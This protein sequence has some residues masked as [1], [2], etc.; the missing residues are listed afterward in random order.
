MIHTDGRP[1]ISSYGS[2][3]AP[4]RS[5]AVALLDD[6][7]ALDVRPLMERE[8]AGLRVEL[9]LVAG[10]LIIRVTEGLGTPDERELVGNVPNSEAHE[11][12]AHPYLYVSA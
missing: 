5:G 12:F 7:L 2:A 1:T 8:Y 3:P 11:A 6:I 9:V 10:G 4:V